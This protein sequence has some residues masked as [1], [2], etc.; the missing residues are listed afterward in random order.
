MQY[1]LP[2]FVVIGSE[3]NFLLPA[4]E[5][6]RSVTNQEQQCKPLSRVV[7]FSY[8]VKMIPSKNTRTFPIPKKDINPPKIRKG[9]Q[10][11]LIMTD[12]LKTS[13]GRLNIVNYTKKKEFA[14]F[15]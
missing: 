9:I 14:Y 1:N 7:F 15:V 11:S 2:C 12:A 13:Y 3:Y 10:V 8:V 4:F 5:E 6:I